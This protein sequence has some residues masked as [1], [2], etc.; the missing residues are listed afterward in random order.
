MTSES[1]LINLLLSGLL[2]LI[3]QGIRVIIG[4]KKLQDEASTK[5]SQDTKTVFN[6][7]FDSRQIWISLLIGFIAGC[8]A[9]LSRKEDAPIDREVEL[10]IIAAGYAGTDF[11]E[12]V[13]KKILPNA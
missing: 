11:I 8:L 1:L 3:G 12:G 4:L 10:A 2:G 13:F 9:N 7:L 5:D 6:Q